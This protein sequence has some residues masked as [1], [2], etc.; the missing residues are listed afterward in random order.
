[1]DALLINREAELNRWRGPH[2]NKQAPG[3]AGAALVIVTH[4][5]AAGKVAIRCRGA[6]DYAAEAVQ[7]KSRW[8]CPPDNVPI[9]NRDPAQGAERERVRYR[10]PRAWRRINDRQVQGSECR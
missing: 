8:Q 9:I 6:A 5:Q 10:L 7:R 2:T 3:Y 1:A 4:A